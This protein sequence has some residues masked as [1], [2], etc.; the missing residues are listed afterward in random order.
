MQWISSVSLVLELAY[1][2]NENVLKKCPS[3][4]T[5][6]TDNALFCPH[7]LENGIWGPF[8]APLKPRVPTQ[9]AFCIPISTMYYRTSTY[10]KY[11]VKIKK[12]SP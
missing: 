9:D 2:G 1:H 5:N 7:L 4:E 12:V 8:P 3:N 11:V 6:A 10:Q